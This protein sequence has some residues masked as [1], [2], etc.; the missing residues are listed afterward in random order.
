MVV[1]CSDLKRLLSD[2]RG[3]SVGRARAALAEDPESILSNH[4]AAYKYL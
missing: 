4:M 1:K 2:W 3:G